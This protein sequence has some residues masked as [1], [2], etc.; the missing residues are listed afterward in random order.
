MSTGFH[1]SR[2][3]SGTRG[4]S[5]KTL[6]LSRSFP[7]G[8]SLLPSLRSSP[9]RAPSVLRN[10]STSVGQSPSASCLP[11]ASNVQM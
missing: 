9:L 7:S 11:A 8:G 2:G 5:P 6:H 1:R 10:A 4:L 3:M